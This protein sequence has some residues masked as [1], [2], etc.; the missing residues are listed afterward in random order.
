MLEVID[1]FLEEEEAGEVRA[2]TLNN[3]VADRPKYKGGYISIELTDKFPLY[4]VLQ[5]KIK[6]KLSILHDKY[7]FQG[8]IFCYDEYCDGVTPHA[9]PGAINVNIWCTPDWCM[10][11]KTKNGL[12]VYNVKPPED[13]EWEDYNRDLPKIE[14]YLEEKQAVGRKIPYKYKRA[15]VFDSR[16]FHETDSVSTKPGIGNKRINITFMY[17]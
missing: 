14:T 5:E 8:W 16:Y 11:D 13:W 9:D 1:N 17:K 3:L 6:Q 15:T 12:I 7:F 4:Q 2:F 10:L